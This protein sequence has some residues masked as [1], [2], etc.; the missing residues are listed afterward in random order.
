MAKL[1][2][3]KITK[4]EREQRSEPMIAEN[5]YPMYPYGLGVNLDD[6]TLEKLEIDAADL[7]VG[8]VLTLVARVE[9]TS[10]S[11]MESKGGTPHQSVG[12]QITELCLEATE[13]GADHAA[14]ALYTKDGK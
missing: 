7:E 4:A 8:Q 10:L 2:S 1:V 9:V 6:E 11:S 5:D 13:S 3:V 12:L 14:D